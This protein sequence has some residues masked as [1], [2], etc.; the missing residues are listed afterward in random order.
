[1]LD[2]LQMACLSISLKLGMYN[3]G[4]KY[5]GSG[6]II[7]Q[8]ALSVVDCFVFCVKALLARKSEYKNGLS[9][10]V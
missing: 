4:G 2:S 6:N 8:R 5:I 1:M 3:Y 9:G 10:S 7:G